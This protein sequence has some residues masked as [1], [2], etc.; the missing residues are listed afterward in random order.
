MK[1]FHYKLLVVGKPSWD[2]LQAVLPDLAYEPGMQRGFVISRESTVSRIKG[3]LVYTRI[4]KIEQVDKD[5]LD[6]VETAVEHLDDLTFELD[7]QKGLVCVH[8]KRGGLAVLYEA[9]DAIPECNVEYDEINLNLRQFLDE[10][11]GAYKKNTIKTLRIHDY[12]A[13]EHMMTNA[14]FKILEPQDA[15]RIADKFADQLDSFTLTLKLPDGACSITVKRNGTI[16]C[17]DDAPDELL[18]FCKD[19]LPRFHEAE[20]E[21]AEVV[22]PVGKAVDNLRKHARDNNMTVEIITPDGKAARLA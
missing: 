11:Q 16:T 18:L 17:G 22:D 13:R 12:L 21:T 3:R 1:T 7:F 9:L 14:A 20:V 8:G 2:A 6:H 19:L 10:L 5:T 4:G 15:E